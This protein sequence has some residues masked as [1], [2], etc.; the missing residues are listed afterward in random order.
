[1]APITGTTHEVKMIG[2]AKGYRFEPASLTIK[3]GD[4]VKFVNVIG[5]PH[6]VA[7]DAATIP[8]DV[9]SQLDANMGTD[10]M[11]ELS[12]ALKMNPG[13]T[14]TISFANIKPGTYA[15]HCVPHL[16]MNMKGTITVQ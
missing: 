11:G 14:I 8:A 3:P 6:N 4:G 13:E 16:A 5:G 2:D 1:M 7:F 9:R 15:Y 12:S 10:K